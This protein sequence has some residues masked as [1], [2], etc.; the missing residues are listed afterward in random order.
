MTNFFKSMMV[1]VVV[2]SLT[3][4]SGFA[5][6]FDKSKA[7]KEYKIANDYM[8]TND[9]SDNVIFGDGWKYL[10]DLVSGI[11]F[12]GMDNLESLAAAG[13]VNNEKASTCV[14]SET[15]ILLCKDFINNTTNAQHQQ[16][17]Q[18]KIVLFEA[19]KRGA[20][21]NIRYADMLKKV[22]KHYANSAVRGSSFNEEV[23]D[24]LWA[25]K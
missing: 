2:F 20:G 12:N 1:I 21:G 5:A 16:F 11:G 23:R 4:T 8:N 6:S 25:T 14:I 15:V 19:Y 17:C 7:E 18:Q 10:S 3:L 24:R 13:V 22:R 9:S